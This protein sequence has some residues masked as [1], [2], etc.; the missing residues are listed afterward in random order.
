MHEELSKT[1]NIILNLNDVCGKK[2]ITQEEIN[3]Q[4]ANLEDYQR[5]FFELDNILS[6]IERD[7]LDS[8][9]DTVEALVQLHLK[10]SDYIWHIDQIHELVKKMVGNYRENFKNN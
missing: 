4:K 8:V 2:I 5:M 9:D 3:E 6:R 10:Y 7:E 1:L